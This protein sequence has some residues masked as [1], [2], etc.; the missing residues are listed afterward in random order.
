MD[1]T[2]GPPRVLLAGIFHE[3]HCFVDEP[4]GL[5]DFQVRWGGALDQEKGSSSPLGGFYEVADREGWRVLPAVDCRALPSGR[6]EDEVIEVFWEGFREAWEAGQGDL[7]AVFL[8]LHG[9]MVSRSYPDVEGEILG[10]LRQLPG[11]DTMPVFGVFDLH[12]NVS[13]AMV[14]RADAL[15]AY[16]ENPHTDAR[17]AATRAADW[18]ARSL[19]SGERPSMVHRATGLHWIPSRTATAADPMRSLARQARKIE[20][21]DPATWAVN[22][23]P[24]FCYGDSPERGLSFQWVGTGSVEEAAGVL[25]RLVERARELD[26]EPSN[27]EEVSPEKALEQIEKSE[28]TGPVV[29]VEPSDN[30]GGGTPGDMTGLLRALLEAGVEN[31]AICLNDP[32]AVARLEGQSPG[33]RAML[34]LG[35]KGSQLDAGPVSL[36]VELVSLS[37][38]HFELEDRQ[39]HLASVSGDAFDMG[40]CA[41]VRHG[42]LLILLTSNR[43]PPFDLG[44]WRSQGIEPESLKVIVVKAAVAHRQAYDPIA[45]RMIWVDTPGPCTS[46][47]DRLPFRF[48]AKTR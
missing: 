23:V 5:A 28:D 30:I 39:S 14:D 1:H 19:V 48:P 44:Q 42:G 33:D 6:V 43:T 20:A 17:Q 46:R 26:A 9:A 24:G 3:T 7:D 13:E 47:L 25:D 4:T 34:D 18:L 32:E 29:L 35:G 45:A 38:G 12:G 27:L 31:A 36:E 41:V 2:P 37:D 21:E 22:V 15:F 40:P 10:R 8:V 11:G 16:R